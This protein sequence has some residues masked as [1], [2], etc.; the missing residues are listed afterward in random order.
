MFLFFNSIDEIKE[1]DD[2]FQ[3]V[4][5]D[6]TSDQSEYLSTIK[7]DTIA[8]RVYRDNKK[9]ELTVKEKD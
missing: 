3:T 1:F 5:S 2:Y 6:F 4:S 9:V 7:R 8:A